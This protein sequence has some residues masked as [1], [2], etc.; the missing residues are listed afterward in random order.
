ME[1]LPKK[2]TIAVVGNLARF[3]EPVDAS[4]YSLR[5]ENNVLDIYTNDKALQ[6]QLIIEFQEHLRDYFEPSNQLI[7][8]RD[9]GHVI[10]A[11]K[12]PH[13][14]YQYKVFL[15]A[16]KANEEEKKDY[17]VWLEK[18]QQKIKISGAVKDWFFRTKWNWDRRYVYV[19][20]EQMLL[21][22]KL[23]NPEVMGTIYRYVLYDK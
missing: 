18:Q 12:L 16:H 2:S 15:L 9:D 23:K 20:N 5:A 14:K 17:I 1:E 21:M 4:I 13:K 8:A 19:E 10:F 7:N 6:D 11:N 22:M 3:L